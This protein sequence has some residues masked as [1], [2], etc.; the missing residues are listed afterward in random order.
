MDYEEKKN[1]EAIKEIYD[2]NKPNLAEQLRN[3]KVE[4]YKNKLLTLIS[5][6]DELTD[7]STTKI[8]KYPIPEELLFVIGEDD[9]KKIDERF[10]EQLKYIDLSNI[11]FSDCNPILIDPQKLFNK[12]LSNTVFLDDQTR[13]NNRFPFNSSSNFENV[14]LSGSIITTVGP[15][16][17]NFKG[18]IGDSKT[19]KIGQNIVEV[20]TNK[21]IS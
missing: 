1:N 15:V 19:F 6:L 18:M 8:T 13:L 7:E 12:D 10:I 17:V 5:S 11:N 3:Q 14:N 4:E 9:V 20:Q 21:K 2:L 16:F